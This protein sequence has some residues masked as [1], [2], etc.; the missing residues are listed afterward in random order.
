MSLD[1]SSRS[2][3]KIPKIMVPEE[4]LM[5]IVDAARIEI[6]RGL[7][8]LKDVATG[9]DLKKFL[10]VCWLPFRRIS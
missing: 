9:T 3:P 1:V 10:L 8:A 6:N 5:K 4:Y 2:P 7:V